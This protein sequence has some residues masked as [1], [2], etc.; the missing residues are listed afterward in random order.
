MTIKK[1]I[2]IGIMVLSAN[3][4]AA[5]GYQDYN[6]KTDFSMLAEECRLA[7]L[8]LDSISRYQERL[9][10]I[11]NLDGASVYVA[12]Q[13]IQNLQLKEAN[14]LL[15]K[16]IILTKFAID[17]DC[18]RQDELKELVERLQNIQKNLN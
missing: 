17:I 18:H 10:C 16:A 14:S 6:D 5:Q 7:A 15:S 12:S 4:F 8:K 2:S 9:A 13:Y 3:I 11:T 1:F